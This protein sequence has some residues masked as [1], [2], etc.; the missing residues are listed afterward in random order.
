[1][2]L[3]RDDDPPLWAWLVLAIVAL[4]LGAVIVGAQDAQAETYTISMGVLNASEHELDAG[5]VGYFAIGVS[6]LEGTT[7]VTPTGSK[8]WLHLRALRGR[9]I[10]LVVRV[11]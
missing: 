5:G 10:E 6:P 4:M 8:P 2:S 7:I 3:I 11:R 1:M 9:Q